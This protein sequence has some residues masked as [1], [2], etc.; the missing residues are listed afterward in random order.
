MI[1]DVTDCWES[2]R[3]AG[4]LYIVRSTIEGLRDGFASGP[5]AIA[6]A[7]AASICACRTTASRAPANGATRRTAAGRS[8]W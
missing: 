8:G 2:E 5:A 3:I 7:S 1:R 6:A 4:G